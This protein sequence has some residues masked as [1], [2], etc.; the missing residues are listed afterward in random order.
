MRDSRST[1][2][3][4]VNEAFVD[5]MDNLGAPMNYAAPFPEIVTVWNAII[6]EYCH[7]QQV[8]KSPKFPELNL[9][10]YR[11][12]LAAGVDQIKDPQRRAHMRALLSA[13]GWKPLEVASAP[14]SQPPPPVAKVGKPLWPRRLARKLVRET[15]NSANHLARRLVPSRPSA[16]ADENCL[17]EK[18]VPRVEAFSVNAIEFQSSEDALQYALSHPRER[19]AAS[20]HETLIQGVAVPLP[21]NILSF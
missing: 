1:N 16:H 19:A 3:G 5:F 9:D 18:Q 4:V 13:R 17:V 10:T 14:A 20:D 8:T 21:E 6:S 12:A 15:K 2:H 7:V 11:Q